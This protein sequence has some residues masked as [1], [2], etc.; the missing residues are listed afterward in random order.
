MVRLDESSKA[1]LKQAAELRR[2]TVS[3]YVRQV[4]VAQAER[5]VSAA[6]DRVIRMTPSEQLEFWTALANPKP[7]TR[8]QKKLGKIMRGEA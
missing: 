5:E 6:S 3:D 2:L 7:L 8:R 4:T 1:A